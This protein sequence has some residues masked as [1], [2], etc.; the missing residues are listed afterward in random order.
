MLILGIII[1]VPDLLF[2]PLIILGKG[3]WVRRGRVRVRIL[4][5]SWRNKNLV[6][7][8]IIDSHIHSNSNDE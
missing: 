6:G 3:A 7:G 4:K 1:L 8:R 2:L 5:S